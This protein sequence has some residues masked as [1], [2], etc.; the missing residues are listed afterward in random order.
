MFLCSGLKQTC[1][2]I[3]SMSAIKT[4]LLAQKLKIME[5][6]GSVNEY[7]RYKQSLNEGPSISQLAQTQHA[8]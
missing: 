2:N 3:F 1:K 8:L 4:I 5:S 6:N 7:P